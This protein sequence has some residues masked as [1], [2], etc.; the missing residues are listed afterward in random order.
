MALNVLSWLAL[1]LLATAAV[2][3]ASKDAVHAESGPIDGTYRLRSRSCDN[4]ELPLNGWVIRYVVKNTTGTLSE[5]LPDSCVITTV[6]SLNYPASGKVVSTS[7]KV[8]CGSSCAN[9]ECIASDAPG[10]PEKY[11][12]TYLD[13]SLNL[14]PEVKDASCSGPETLAYASGT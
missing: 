14:V 4:L 10:V 1:T 7:Q 11:D 2:S 13:G 8:M 3:C 6:A 9:N 12:Y 5:T